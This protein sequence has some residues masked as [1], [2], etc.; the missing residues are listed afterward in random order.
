MYIFSANKMDNGSEEEIGEPG[1]NYSWIRYIYLYTN[2]LGKTLSPSA[3][4]MSWTVVFYRE[5]IIVNVRKIIN[6]IFTPAPPQKN[7]K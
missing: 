7:V 2:T 1:S 5:K 4:S 3:P 6:K